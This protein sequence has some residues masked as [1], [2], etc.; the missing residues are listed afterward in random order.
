[1]NAV[2]YYFLC[3]LYRQMMYF[4]MNP[5]IFHGLVLLTFEQF[6]NTKHNSNLSSALVF[7]ESAHMFDDYR[8]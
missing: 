4:Y 1:M 6:W 5:Y 2:N 8:R 3:D 7:D